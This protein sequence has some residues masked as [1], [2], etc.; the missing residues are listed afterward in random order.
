MD[1][2]PIEKFVFENHVNYGTA[3]MS[4]FHDANPIYVKVPNIALQYLTLSR[5]DIVFSINKL[6]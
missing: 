3:S 2:I 6:S 5:P 4:N 1:D